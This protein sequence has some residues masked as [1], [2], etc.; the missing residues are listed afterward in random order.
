VRGVHLRSWARAA[1][2]VAL[3]SLSGVDPG[4][5]ELVSLED[6]RTGASVALE[7]GAAALH[8]VF[9]ATWCPP[10]VRELDALV[11]LE[12]R[13]SERGYRLVLIAVQNRHTAPRLADFVAERKPP[14]RLLFDVGGAAQKRWSAER[15]PEHVVLDASG[16]E[17]A[18]AGSLDG[19]IEAAIRGLVA[20]GRGGG[21]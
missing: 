4:A 18:R 17:I 6:P 2:C 9:F 10:C 8:L 20:G 7:P 1:A 5:A 21:G 12:A 16:R 11:E 19:G 15:L 14:G 3:C 13:W